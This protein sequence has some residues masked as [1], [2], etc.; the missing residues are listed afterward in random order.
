MSLV[1]LTHPHLCSALRSQARRNKCIKIFTY[2]LPIVTQTAAVVEYLS[3]CH[4]EFPSA[5]FA[6]RDVGAGC[7]CFIASIIICVVLLLIEC[8]TPSTWPGELP[9][10]D[11]PGDGWQLVQSRAGPFFFHPATQKM[12]WTL[13]ESA[14]DIRK[15]P[16]LR[17]QPSVGVGDESTV[18]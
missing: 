15:E 17:Q 3:A 7:W 13:P 8:L 14:A 16:P 6:D 5:S 9:A 1:S 2:V 18:P 12:S 4:G 11:A 10:P